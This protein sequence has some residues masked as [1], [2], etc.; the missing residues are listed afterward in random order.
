MGTTL[1]FIFIKEAV[2]ILFVIQFRNEF[3]HLFRPDVARKVKNSISIKS[4]ETVLAIFY[5]M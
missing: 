5:N 4:S 2:Q 1:H 3:L